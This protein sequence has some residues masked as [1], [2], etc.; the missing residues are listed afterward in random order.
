M[1]TLEDIAWTWGRIFLKLSLVFKVLS[2]SQFF[3]QIERN[4]DVA[5][6][7]LMFYP[8]VKFKKNY[9]VYFRRYGLDTMPD[10]RTDGKA[11]TYIPSFHGGLIFTRRLSLFMNLQVCNFYHISSIRWKN[12]T[13]HNLQ[14]S[15]WMD[16][17]APVYAL[18][19]TGWT[20]GRIFYH[21]FLWIDNSQ[22]FLQLLFN[23][24]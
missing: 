21:F 20:R 22:P 7:L 14:S 24:N 10:R 9:I 16:S 15:L 13:S 8:Y 4:H 11:E 19:K 6:L 5:H 17:H 12:A 18:R 2:L 23:S 1:Y 3:H